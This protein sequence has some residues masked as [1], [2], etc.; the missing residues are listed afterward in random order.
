MNKL[1]VILI[2]LCLLSACGGGSEDN[3]V[4]NN[5]SAD[6]S[7]TPINPIPDTN[8]LPDTSPDPKSTSMEDLYI[9]PGFDLSTKFSLIVNA[10][11]PL[12]GQRAYL[13]ICQKLEGQKTADRNNCVFRTPLSDSPIN[14]ILTI[15]RS[16][17]KLVAEVWLYDNNTTPMTY[18]WEYDVSA[19]KQIFELR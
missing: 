17:I 3:T 2:G 13:N 15:S 9:K 14:E 1:I 19:E 10:D 12:D 8:P 18:E 4:S 6:N 7:V 11:I 5:G 16:D